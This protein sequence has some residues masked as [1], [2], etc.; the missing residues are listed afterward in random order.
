MFCRDFADTSIIA[1]ADEGLA[2]FVVGYRRPVAPD[3]LFVWQVAVD[4]LGRGR[5]LAVAMLVGLLC[6]PVNRDVRFLETTVTLSN[7]ASQRLFRGLARKLG[8]ACEETRVF[9]AERFAEKYH[10][11][12]VLFRVGPILPSTLKDL[13]GK[14]LKKA[15]D[16]SDLHWQD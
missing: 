16:Y 14:L 6:R 3:T 13:Q 2:G 4:C 12:E 8:A 1:E 11:E 10:E 7:E 15:S 9:A 5:G